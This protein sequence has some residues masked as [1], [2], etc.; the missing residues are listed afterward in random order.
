MLCPYHTSSMALNCGGASPEIAALGRTFWSGTYA[1]GSAL[2]YVAEP[3]CGGSANPG[4]RSSSAGLNAMRL[5]EPTG[6]INSSAAP[7]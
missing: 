6:M 5:I 1:V 4:R 7:S 2:L 3:F